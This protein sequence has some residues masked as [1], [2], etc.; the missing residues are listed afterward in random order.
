MELVN[1]M[2]FDAVD[3]GELD[4]S[5]RQQ[6]AT[7]V[8]TADLDIAGVREALRKATFE[9]KPQWRATPQSPG[10][11]RR[12]RLKRSPAQHRRGQRAG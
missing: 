1:D 4:E 8:Y 2:G 9:R 12:A 3:A 10:D 11:L 5:R 6:P 7:P